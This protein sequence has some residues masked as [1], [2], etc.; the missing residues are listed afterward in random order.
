MTPLCG[1]YL[2][3]QATIRPDCT[4][5]TSPF[6]LL[7]VEGLVFQGSEFGSKED[8]LDAEAMECGP[9]GSPHPK[10]EAYVAEPFFKI[11]LHGV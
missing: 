5:L 3:A 6:R 8:K 10:V 2:E 4:P 9:Q 1:P 11:I 7:P